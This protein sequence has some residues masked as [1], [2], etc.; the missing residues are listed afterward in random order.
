MS[1]YVSFTIESY[2]ESVQ[3]SQR[4]SVGIV[5]L[6]EIELNSAEQSEVVSFNIHFWNPNN[7][8][9]WEKT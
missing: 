1:R 4:M 5:Q 3:V 6:R 7:L 9:P 8:L 2:R